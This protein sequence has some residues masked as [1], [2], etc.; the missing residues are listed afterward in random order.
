MLSAG[1]ATPSAGMRLHSWGCNNFVT[2]AIMLGICEAFVD[3]SPDVLVN[4]ATT[5][6][7]LI[8]IQLLLP[9]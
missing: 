3:A 7:D 4:A 9:L 8:D 6:V 2:T 1:V 5:V